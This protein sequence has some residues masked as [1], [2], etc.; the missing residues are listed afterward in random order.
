MVRA[1]VPSA[2]KRGPANHTR[3]PIAAK[4]G[5][6]RIFHR[7]KT[8]SQG[9]PER[10]TRS[11][12][13]SLARPTAVNRGHKLHS[14]IPPPSDEIQTYNIRAPI[15]VNRGITCA[16]HNLPTKHK[17]TMRA[18]RRRARRPHGSV[19]CCAARNKKNSRGPRVL[20]DRRPSN[21][22][23]AKQQP[24]A[25]ASAGRLNHKDSVSK[26]KRLS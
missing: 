19:F 21:R 4:R 12:A 22:P 18:G 6:T 17:R 15:A 16:S 2:S 10:Q 9:T 7:G 26:V 25:A 1:R 8:R 5:I 3:V 20:S 13:V 23:R 14:R 24:M 11:N